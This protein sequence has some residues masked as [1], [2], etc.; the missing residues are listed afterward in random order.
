MKPEDQRIAI[1][2]ATHYQRSPK[3]ADAPEPSWGKKGEKWV[4]RELFFLKDLPDYLN[5]HNAMRGA[6]A[7]LFMIGTSRHGRALDVHETE[8]L[9]LSYLVSVC[10]RPRPEL[11]ATAA[12]FAEAFL[13]TLN[14]WKP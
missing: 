4:E 7:H 10:K 13:K 3:R 11:Y 6:M 2:E 14:L 12:E 8:D 9:F 5:D 1:A